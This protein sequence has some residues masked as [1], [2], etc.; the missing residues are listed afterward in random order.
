MAEPTSWNDRL[1]TWRASQGLSREALAT[2]VGVSAE[3]I[4]AYELAK[5]RPPRDVLIAVLNGLSV[6]ARER[7]V[8][9]SEVGY[10]SGGQR[11]GSD[12]PQPEH[13]FD[14]C[15]REIHLVEW[16]AVV[17]DEAMDVLAANRAAQRLWGVDLSRE[18]N[19]PVQRN[20][21]AQMSNPRIADQMANWEEAVRIL[22]TL[23]KGSFGD[24]TEE[25]PR[26]SYYQAVMQHFLAG[27]PRY[28]QDA[29]RIWMEVEPEIY[30][31]RFQYPVHWRHPEFGVLRF[32]VIAN[33]VN[34]GER[35]SLNDWVPQDGRAWEAVRALSWSPPATTER[36][37][38][39]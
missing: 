12:L 22:L 25:N 6:H 11:V 36:S 3:S 34:R 26:N 38:E 32:K 28:V 9:F 30:K 5:R 14:D 35:L 2:A 37:R 24:I 20:L 18:F 39:I 21:L 31:W 19:T 15:L 27:D 29:M 4:K 17:T 8:I 1:R 13:T 33:L 10:A 16:P 23:V 7:E